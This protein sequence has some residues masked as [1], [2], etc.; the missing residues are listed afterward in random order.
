MLAETFGWQEGL[1]KKFNE[2]RAFYIV[3]ILSLIVGLL[4][5]FMGISPMRA[6]ILT[7]ILYGVTSPVMIA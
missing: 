3:M 5:N 7:A 2:A 6:L 1:D 4:I